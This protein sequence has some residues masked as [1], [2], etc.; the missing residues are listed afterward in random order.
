[1][2]SPRKTSILHLNSEAKYFFTRQNLQRFGTA[3]TSQAK[4]GSLLAK[5]AEITLFQVIFCIC[6]QQ[7]AAQLERDQ[8]TFPSKQHPTEKLPS[9][10]EAVQYS[11]YCSFQGRSFAR[12]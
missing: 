10:P 8:Q 2:Q 4:A 6:G 5:G 9:S 12:G 11:P 7:I 1:M 3:V